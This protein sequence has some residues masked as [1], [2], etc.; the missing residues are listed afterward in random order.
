MGLIFSTLKQEMRK[1]FKKTTIY[2]CSGV[3][4]VS[5]DAIYTMGSYRGT[6]CKFYLVAPYSILFYLTVLILPIDVLWFH[7]RY[8]KGIEGMVSYGIFRLRL[9]VFYCL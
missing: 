4:S 5:W 3:V 1:M 8:I 6:W 7:I 2:F 9:Y